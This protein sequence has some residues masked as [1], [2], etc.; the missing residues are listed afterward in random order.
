MILLSIGA[1]ILKMILQSLTI[2]TGVGNAVFGDR[3]V[4]IGFLHLVFLGFVSPF[5]VAYYT[6]ENILNV[7]VK[8]AIHAQ[9][10]F[11]V[12]VV[13]NEL[14]LMLQGV[15]AMFLKSSHWFSWALWIISIG[16]LVGVVLTF[17]A[18]IKSAALSLKLDEDR[19]EL[20]IK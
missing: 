17:V 14:A 3:P 20:L 15:G 9:I 19:R 8:L 18:V 5:I 12:F 1:F 16:L 11:I 2:F 10:I 13:C 6:Q 7:K 4:I